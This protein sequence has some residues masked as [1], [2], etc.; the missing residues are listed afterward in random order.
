[1][2]E[3]LQLEFIA[4][5]CF[6]VVIGVRKIEHTNVDLRPLQ[7]LSR[8][9][10]VITIVGVILASLF[11]VS[12]PILGITS[13]TEK[14]IS[15][16]PL[17]KLDFMYHILNV[18][19]CIFFLADII[20]KNRINYLTIAAYIGFLIISFVISGERSV[21]I[22]F[23]VAL[24]VLYHVIYRHIPK[25]VLASVATIGMYISSI[26]ENYK[27][28]LITG[29]V[30]ETEA[31]GSSASGIIGTILGSELRTASENLSLL[32]MY[33]P[34]KIGYF[35]G[36]LLLK[37]IARA[38]VPGFL[39]DRSAVMNTSNWFTE[40]FFPQYW[41]IGG[42]VGFSMVGV[43]YVNF[44]IAGIIGVFLFLA[45]IL[46]YLYRWSGHS[47]YGL[48]V[49]VNIIPVYVFAIRG[50]MSGPI[51]HSAKH[52]LIP[53]LVITIVGQVMRRISKGADR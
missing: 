24:V 19:V 47:L 51:S 32:L 43:G 44:G 8:G 46:K 30:K 4:V 13:K 53:L 22:N 50:D 6:S 40:T 33:V 12:I 39:I 42:G 18:N 9:N 52:I 21:F 45:V 38:V 10:K 23:V 3:A 14:A 5:I 48:L 36:E 49:Y 1:M 28:F 2:E 41:E 26:M 37:D 7:V 17:L 11:L 15:A 34:E 35:Y 31:I 16:S 29:Q 20:K 27:M 25:L